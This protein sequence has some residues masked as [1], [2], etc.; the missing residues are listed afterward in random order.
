MRH[1]SDR[2]AGVR[3]PVG[4]W[5]KNAFFKPQRTDLTSLLF[6]E[7]VRSEVMDFSSQ[8]LKQQW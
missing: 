7:A 5:L 6:W 4:T 2:W 3:K 8:M 1:E